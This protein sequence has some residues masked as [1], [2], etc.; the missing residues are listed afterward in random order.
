M[1]RRWLLLVAVAVAVGVALV[2]AG[3]GGK[4]YSAT[5]QVVAEAETS[6]TSKAGDVDV[7]ATNVATQVVMLKS[8]T[9]AL[10]VSRRLGAKAAKV[11]AITIGAVGR[12]RVIDITVE[13]SDPAIARDGA[14]TYAQTFVDLRRAAAV[15]SLQG[16]ARILL[17]RVQQAKAQLDDL[18]SRI[19][20]GNKSPAELQA[21]HNQRDA[22]AAQQN[23]FQQKYDKSVA[24]APVAKGSVE[25]LQAASL[26]AHANK[27]RVVRSGLIGLALGLLV[28]AGAAF[29]FEVLDDK[30][31]DP[32]D[33]E[34]GDLEV[35]GVVPLDP[36]WTDSDQARLVSR[37]RPGSTEAAAYETVGRA[38]QHAGTRGPLRTL[39]VVDPVG[40]E[41]ATTT[42][43]NLAVALARS[44]RRVTC[45]DC[46]LR[47]PRVHEF[48]SVPVT[49]GFTTVMLGDVPLS[50]AY[51]HVPAGGGAVRV[52][53]AGPAPP[54]PEEVLQTGRVDELLKALANDTDVV[55]ID[56]PAVLA[57]ED[58][59]VLARRVDGAV[60]VVGLGVT[61]R[62]ELTR[63][64]AALEQAG[65]P[66]VGIVL[67]TL[68]SGHDVGQPTEDDASPP[69]SEELATAAPRPD[70]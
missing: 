25:M 54:H 50:A 35:L 2:L 14:T 47:R 38:V 46:D 11:S 67:N 51:H 8:R 66:V 68:P 31:K 41:G 56:A 61:R 53:A 43:A 22:I 12:S 30:V 7:Q 64:V 9:V 6:T 63:T 52:L 27:P 19:S 40:S 16:A 69:D 60:V 4:V 10:E 24:D 62:R 18:D 21:L 13:S 65:A 15:D 45:V 32:A 49:P 70:Q 39:L 20:S 28:G 36:D 1:R 33:L 59:E 58:A 44:G 34:Q 3:R 55:L 57:Y 17:Q 5:A 42:M 29:L 48:F 23:L 37:L 26:P